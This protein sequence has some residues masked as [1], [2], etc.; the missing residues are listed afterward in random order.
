M[1]RSERL[2]KE[3]RQQPAANNSGG[4]SSGEHSNFARRDPIGHDGAP[5]TI[6]GFG[7][8]EMVSAPEPF[9]IIESIPPESRCLLHKMPPRT[10][11]RR[12]EISGLSAISTFC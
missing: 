6:D 2:N 11:L 8:P 3:R 4:H 1:Q 7:V 9:R 12:R 5:S 10:G